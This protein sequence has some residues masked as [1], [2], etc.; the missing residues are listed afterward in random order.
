MY[1]I[2]FTQPNKRFALGLNYNGRNG[3]LFGNATK[4]YQLKEKTLK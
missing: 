4:I 3:F 1:P 2:H